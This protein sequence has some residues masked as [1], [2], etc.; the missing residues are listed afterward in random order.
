M[1]C[2]RPKGGFKI[3]AET[4]KEHILP[5]VSAGPKGVCLVVNSELRAVEDLKLVARLVSLKKAIP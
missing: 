1:I 4:G 2:G 5:A 3:A